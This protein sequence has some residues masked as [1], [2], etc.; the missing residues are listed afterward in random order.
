MI[1]LGEIQKLEVKRN[2]SI[3]MFLNTK[4]SRRDEEDVLLPKKEIPEG[5]KV[6]DEIEVFIYKD[7]QDRFISTTKKPK[8]TL[9]EIAPL[10]VVDIT[11]IGAFLDWGLEKDLFLPFKE[12]SVKLEKGR[13]YLIGLYIDKS[14]RLC[15]T[16]KIRDFLRNDSP[17]K[18]N[19]WAKGTIYSIN[20]EFGAFVAVD[21]KYEGLIPK[22][23]LIGV[24]VEGEVVDVRIARVKEDGKL[25]LSLKDKA[26]MEI[27]G[28]AEKILSKTIK[29]GGILLL[30]DY[31][32][33]Q[34][35]R[36]E[37]N[38]SKSAFKKAVGRLLKEGKIEF[39]ENGIKVK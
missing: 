28:D 25:D 27:E 1:E 6:G 9:G 15:G 7:S 22:K 21:N 31:S 39:V 38:M 29:N 11:K 20:D 5:I 4:D 8:L 32:S 24:Y 37:L 34:E 3:G 13:E 18:E 35:I 2:T 14:D 26:Y 23:E 10:Q 12:Q 16:M 17:Y 19:D 36:R 33:P 30:N